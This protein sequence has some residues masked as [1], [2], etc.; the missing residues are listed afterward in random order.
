MAG[1]LDT[2]GSVGQLALAGYPGGAS[3]VNMI[4]D[5]KKESL[6]ATT[7]KEMRD[8]DINPLGSDG[9]NILVDKGLVTSLGDLAK[10]HELAKKDA[11][12]L[13]EMI[14][15]AGSPTTPD[16]L[17]ESV[18]NKIGK[19][20][21]S[22]ALQEAQAKLERAPLEKKRLEQDINKGEMTAPIDPNVLVQSISP[23]VKGLNPT[24]P[25]QAALLSESAKMASA[26]MVGESPENDI[27]TAML[28]AMQKFGLV[29]KSG[30]LHPAYKVVDSLASIQQGVTPVAAQGQEGTYD[31]E[32]NQVSTAAP[33]G[34]PGQQGGQQDVKTAFNKEAEVL[35]LQV[36]RQ[37]PKLTYEKAML[38]AVNQ[39][40]SSPKWQT[41][42][43]N[44]RTR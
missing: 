34:G 39:L 43:A 44:Y 22:P 42:L 9:F 36:L 6:F 27:Q 30:W 2:L 21:T 1:F 26:V 40:K 31:T 28:K 14:K 18:E 15:T 10:Y 37:N 19:K 7:I 13:T 24:D 35:T 32:G 23:V 16:I 33:T 17:R 41:I 25:R 3:F 8:K 11:N 4:N 12:E 29:E 20:I 38:E 5:N